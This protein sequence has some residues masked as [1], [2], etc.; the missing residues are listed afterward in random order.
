[1]ECAVIKE[2]YLF[3]AAKL[4]I[5]KVL[6]VLNVRNDALAFGILSITVYRT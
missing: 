1:V 2:P 5:L 4:N 3:Y 6:N